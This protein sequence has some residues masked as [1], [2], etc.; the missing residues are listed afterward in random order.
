MPAKKAVPKKAVKKVAKKATPPKKKKTFEIGV[1]TER[2]GVAL[3][4]TYEKAGYKYISHRIADNDL[5][6]LKFLDKD[7]D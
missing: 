4:K 5:I 2:G 3:R 7:K 6:M 1:F